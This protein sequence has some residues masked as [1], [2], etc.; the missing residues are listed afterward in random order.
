MKIFYASLSPA[1]ALAM[2]LAATASSLAQTT[3]VFRQGL[4]GYAGTS[5]TMLHQGAPT[6]AAGSGTTMDVVGGTAAKQSL[7]KFANIIGTGTNQIPP[8]AQILSA[9]LELS[10]WTAGSGIAVH[11]MNKAWTETDTWSSMVDGLQIGD[12]E[13]HWSAVDTKTNLPRGLAS[14]D[15]AT[16]VQEWANAAEVNEGWALLPSD[17]S[18]TAVQV[19]TRESTFS[20]GKTW[21]IKPTLRVTYTGGGGGGGTPPS[22]SAVSPADGATN[23]GSGGA[24]PIQVGVADA[25][26]D[27]LTVTFYGREKTVSTT[28]TGADFSIVMIPDTQ[29]YSENAGTGKIT[30]FRNMTTWM[31]NNRQPLN[32]QFVAH[33]GDMVQ[34]RDDDAQEW[35]NADSAMDIIE[36]PTTTN[37]IHGIPWGGAPG[38][39]DQN[40]SGG[41]NRYWN[42]YFGNTR[43]SGKTY[44]KG[45]YSD[46]TSDANYQFFSASGMDFIVINLEYRANAAMIAWADALIKA[47]PT[48][49][50]IVTSHEI[51]QAYLD[52]GTPVD[53]AP[54]YGQGRAIYEGL[55]NN[56]NFFLMMCG[57][58]HGEGR[59]TETWQGRKIHAVLCNYQTEANG[60]DTWLRY[61]MFSPSKNTITSNVIRTRDGSRR[62]GNDSQ[63]SL[64]Y[65]MGTAA[66]PWTTLGT[67]SRPAG[68]TSA[69]VT[70]TGLQTGKTYEW[71]A[72]V[73]DGGAP[74][75]TAPRTFTVGN[76]VAPTVTLTAPAG[77]STIV[78]PAKV[79]F[80]AT[81][82]D[83]D[84]TVARVEFF[85]GSTKVGDDTSAPFSFSWD[86]AAGSYSITAQ[87]VDNG[88]ARTISAARSI[89][90]TGSGGG[91]GTPVPPTI[92]PLYP[93]NGS[94]GAGGSGRATLQANVAD[95]NNDPLNITFYGRPKATSGGTGGNFSITVMPDTQYYTDNK[96]QYI[97]NWRAQSNWI[98]KN[99]AAENI[100]YNAHVGD[101][102]Q[103]FDSQEYEWVLADG[104]MKIIE[105]PT[106]T[107][108][109]H[110]IPWGAV[111]GNHDLNSSGNRG[112]NDYYNKYF[113]PKRFA[114]RPYFGGGIT[115]NDNHCSYTLFSGGGMDF[116]VVNL[117]HRP[118]SAMISWGDSIL[119]QF[120][121]RRGIVTSHE[122]INDA[123]AAW[124]GQGQAIFD[125]LKNNPNLFLM[126]CGHKHES[127]GENRRSDV[128]SGRTIHTIVQDYQDRAAGGGG[129]FR[130]YK[131]TPATNTISARTIQA[132]TGNLETD[133]NSQFTFP[134]TMN[135]SGGGG[136]TPAP[137]TS[138]GTISLPGG[139][140]TAYLDWTGL[141]A[142][143]EYEWYVAVS[144]GGTPVSSQVQ[145]FTLANNTAPSVSLTGPANGSTINL[146]ATVNFAADATDAT[147]VARV[148]FFAGSLKVGE[149]TTSPY[150]FS[151]STSEGTYQLTAV[152]VDGL[153]ARTTSAVHTVTVASGNNP[154]S[155]SLTAPANGATIPLPGP[156]EVAATASDTDGTV[157]KVE[158]YQGSTLLG[159]DTTSPYSYTWNAS[160]G[161]YSLTAQ[162]IDNGGIRATSPSR[163]ITV[164]NQAPAVSI[165]QPSTGDSFRTGNPV[166]IRA[167]P[168]D[169][170]G[171]IAKV[172][173]FAGTQRLGQRSTS[174]YQ[175]SWGNA[176]AGSHVLTAVAEDNF[177]AQTTSSAINISVTANAAPTVSVT[178]PANGASIPL[179]ATIKLSAAASDTDG[180]IS[181]VEFFLN[182]TKIGESLA[183]PFEFAWTATPGNQILTATASDNDGSTSTSLPVSFTVTNQPPVVSLLSPVDGGSITLPSKVEI[184]ADVSDLDSPLS[185]VEFFNGSTKIGEARALPYRLS[186]SAPPGTHRLSARAT[187]IYGASAS[188]TSANVTVVNPPPSV[189]ISGP[190]SGST[191]NLPG[192]ITISATASDSDGSV[193]KVEFFANSAKIGESTVAPFT[194]AWSPMSGNYTLRAEAHDNLGGSASSANS[195]VT[196]ANPFNSL[197][198]ITITSPT[199]GAKLSSNR[200][201]T[202]AASASDNDGVVTRVE[203]QADGV[204]VGE[205][206][207]APYSFAWPSGPAG[208]RTLRAIATDNDGG[209]RTSQSILVTI[210]DNQAPVV[211]LSSPPNGVS[212]GGSTILITANATDPD[213]TLSKVE[214]F[215]GKTKLG[216]D[217]AA[218]YQLT[219]N[220][221]PVG[222]HTLSA[223]ATDST[224]LAAR[225]SAV[226]VTI[227]ALT[228]RTFQQDA[229]AYSG[230]SDTQLHG[231]NANT[232]YGSSIT[233]SVDASDRGAPVQSL[234]K[235]DGIFGS[236]ALPGGS[237]VQSAALA[238]NITNSGSGVSVHRLL[239]PWSS[240]STWNSLTMG[241]SADGMEAETTPIATLG[242]NNDLANV[243]TGSKSLDVTTA[244][245]SW[246]TGGMNHG[247]VLLPFPA[248]TN[249]VDFSASEWTNTSQRPKLTI[250]FAPP[251]S[252]SSP[253]VVNE[254]R[255]GALSPALPWSDGDAIEFLL[256]RD[257]TAAEL[258]ALRFGDSN[259]STGRK[260]TVW[261]FAGLESI[262]PVFRAGTLLTIRDASQPQ[263]TSYMPSP[264][265][266]DADWNVELRIGGGHVVL[267]SSAGAEGFFLSGADDTVW[268]DATHSGFE[269]FALSHAVGWDDPANGLSDLTLLGTPLAIFQSQIPASHSL[270]LTGGPS[271]ALSGASYEVSADN[272]LGLPN[273]QGS[274]AL[275]IEDLRTQNP[276]PAPYVSIRAT[277]PFAGEFFRPRSASFRV[278]RPVVSAQSGI[279]P[280]AEPMAVSFSTTGSATPGVDYQAPPAS[281]VIPAG[282]ASANLTLLVTPDKLAEGDESII[283]KIN[284]SAAY[285]IGS[286]SSA[287]CII[288]D[289][290]SHKRVH[291]RMPVGVVRGVDEDSDGDGESNLLEAFK[292]THPG[293]SGDRRSERAGLSDDGRPTFRFQ[294]AKDI[295][296]LDGQILWTRD[297][298]SWYREGDSDGFFQPVFERRVVSQP[299][300]NPEQIEAV[301][302]PLIQSEP[303]PK[304]LFFRLQV[305]PLAEE[306]EP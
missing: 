90:V 183:A 42:E 74:V 33:M 228:T 158:F 243:S 84:G 192:P 132:T 125:G 222:S 182:A 296:D 81:A 109:Q 206:L 153:G 129:W 216:E 177:G 217:T 294:K 254:I 52:A 44:Y 120:P 51:L 147:S 212:L 257:M 226:K 116:V 47:N 261:S 83:S 165:S 197:P 11:R 115:A 73:S 121:N 139:A 279:D 306:P 91:G 29:W 225:S 227:V 34:N 211:S 246:A 303:I 299:H 136:G 82:S 164:T 301:V 187:D 78:R 190:A 54:Y 156:V 277:S 49:R 248:G 106:T 59:R 205:D 152:A 224:G 10:V 238:L 237:V 168:S 70:W 209:S 302:A 102:T 15:V 150:T 39:H 38:N 108:L 166:V 289:R 43:W 88:G 140:P 60:G 233:L 229:N 240:N 174:P 256:I 80:A 26:N 24:V 4:N 284:P 146:P 263:D 41:A 157:T 251:A 171:T 218:P 169:A 271:D 62:T 151:W 61:L 133:A 18:T 145:T 32:I 1:I 119:K 220:S 21:E 85:Q 144:D 30:D 231:I 232:A 94:T 241:I 154:P 57:H 180:T 134:Y 178:A 117:R 98:V 97:N 77:G 291:E 12:E 2:A 208:N 163:T 138:L 193:I 298:K 92:S 28:N 278:F 221:V 105:D 250:T 176:T 69:N 149:D 287:L 288:R 19:D 293:L 127:E 68:S 87:A 55:R 276:S 242:A 203:F 186:W 274:N 122:I 35:I 48:R 13:A 8:N 295:P 159:E 161:S 25:D 16:T 126:L 269:D 196:V 175:L 266:P 113:G 286:P 201:V 135:G 118:T 107:L 194:V 45:G 67:A 128:V 219:W 305:E 96:G 6:T 7:V 162:A 204:T 31:V 253:I 247:L 272:S 86:A 280:L 58:W 95:G 297:L 5:D 101:V 198:S 235:F 46:G 300:E 255:R 282:S 281:I 20:T 244:V 273:P 173:F 141:T 17:A 131:F 79:E 210:A 142:G 290:P 181:K 111:P 50:A 172:E 40:R 170:D 63:F 64:P 9:T 191:V 252:L 27:P 268:I 36:N 22:I 267:V 275:F 234:V 112:S 23:V 215:A 65:D 148:E 239:K 283:L 223:I 264:G 137:W 199:Q 72:A 195:S 262:A 249:G 99:R 14:F 114:G 167:V 100:V 188:S 89:T 103:L 124:T 230:A 202:L 285:Q 155:V 93:G 270:A 56:P 66:V 53:Q 184:A 37:L 3:V 304:A 200:T 130:I 207:S 123:N 160:P 245:Q 71:Y 214:F 265:A 213:G 110:G 260:S 75:A 143:T 76:N 104:V 189:A 258:H 179:P 292:G 185:Q 236:N 259:D